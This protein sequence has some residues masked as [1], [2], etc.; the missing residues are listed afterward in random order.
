MKIYIALNQQSIQHWPLLGD[1]CFAAVALQG[2]FWLPGLIGEPAIQKL[3]YIEHM[4]IYIAL[5]QQSIRVINRHKFMNQP[6]IRRGSSKRWGYNEIRQTLGTTINV[7]SR[8]W[9]THNAS[10]LLFYLY[11]QAQ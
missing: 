9:F 1:C 3:I 6:I 5:N 10:D 2:F 7:I 4:K 11:N 8:S